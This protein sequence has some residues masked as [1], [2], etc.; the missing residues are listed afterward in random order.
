MPLVNS[1]SVEYLARLVIL[2]EMTVK[3]HLM[4]RARLSDMKYR[5]CSVESLAQMAKAKMDG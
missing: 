2:R 3:E 5:N 4:H 1:S